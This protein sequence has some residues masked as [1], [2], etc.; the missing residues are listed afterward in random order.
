MA[1]TSNPSPGKDLAQEVKPLPQIDSTDSFS[2][3]EPDYDFTS[4]EFKGI[5]ELVRT[6]VGFEDDPS[7]PVLTFRAI[8]LSCIFCILGSVV[9]QLS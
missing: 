7:T 1:E 2:S 8:L 4:D 6:V 3:T 9:S 5:P